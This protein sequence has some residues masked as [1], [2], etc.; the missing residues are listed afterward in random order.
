MPRTILIVQHGEKERQPGDPGLT[1]LG[2]RQA[3]TTADWLR[4]NEDPVAIW[5]SPLRRAVETA[6]PIASAFTIEARTDDRFRERLNWDGSVSF[7]DFLEDWARTTADRDHRPRIGDSSNDAA[8]RFLAALE[9]IAVATDDGST[10]IVVAHGGVTTDVLRTLV[11]D[12]RLGE[13]APGLPA[14]GV[15]SCAVTR[16][17]GTAGAWALGAPP[18]TAHLDDVGQE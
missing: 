6:A 16:L 10:V 2:R 11:G 5:S 14:D 12:A 18:S 13:L 8:A 9:E 7:E 17:V 1:D 3:G 15:P 4:A